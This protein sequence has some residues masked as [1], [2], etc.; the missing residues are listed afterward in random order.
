[1]T[2]VTSTSEPEPTTTPP[3]SLIPLPSICLNMIVKNESKVIRRLLESVVEYLDSYCICDTG[4][5][6][7][8]VD[9]IR[10]F[11]EE[12]HVPG[13]IT[14]EPFRDFG[15]NRTHA[16][17]SAAKMPTNVSDYLLLMDA[18]MVL[19]RDT[20]LSVADVK[21]RLTR[22]R[23]F[24]VYQGTQT[25]KYKNVRILKNRMGATYWG[26]THEYVKMPEGENVPY[27][28]FAHDE[29]FI[30]DIGDGGSKGDKFKRDIRLLQQGLEELPNND[31]YL[32]Y[33]ANSYRDNG[34][35]REAIETYRR[36][37]EVGGWV[38]ELWQCYYSMGKCYQ[39]LGDM[40]N[41]IFQWM[42]AYHTY[43]KRIENLY[44]MVRYY[45]EKGHNELAYTFYIMADNIRNT[46]V[47]RDYLF[48]Q[49]DIYDY[50]LDYELSIVGYYCNPE[51]KNLVDISMKVIR[52]ADLEDE[53]YRNVLSNYKFYA[54]KLDTKYGLTMN[55][56]NV[57]MLHAIGRDVIAP[58]LGEYVPS[59]PS[60]CIDSRTGD[61]VV[62]VRFVNYRINEEGGYEGYTG[63]TQ[64]H[65]G[66]KNV[67]ARFSGVMKN[68]ERA[69][70]KVGDDQELV[71]DP[72]YNDGR[73][74]GLEDVRLF[75]YDKYRGMG[76]GAGRLIYNAN[77]GLEGTQQRPPA[78]HDAAVITVEHGW[79][80]PDANDSRKIT[81]TNSRLLVYEGANPTLEKN[82]VL[83]PY[84]T[85]DRITL[86]CVYK[87]SPLILG[88]VC[89]TAGR[90]TETH[91]WESDTLPRFFRDVRCSTNGVPV[92]R[93]EIWFLGHLV[94]YENR[95]YYYH[96]M[97]VL[98]AKTLALKKYTPLWTFAGGIVEYT[99]GMV[100]FPDTQRFLIGYST[101]DRETKYT[102]VSR[103]VFDE[104]V[105]FVKA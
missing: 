77:R 28:E 49:T 105:G 93:D 35:H 52:H 98:D 14:K 102:M 95:R 67:V 73:Y 83:F 30:R 75:S 10:T 55:A 26:V 40:P 85:D 42:E 43:P 46:H 16:L 9:I 4:S 86:K 51:R 87:W 31:R 5:T 15:Y 32:Y 62:C 8:T 12:H 21:T 50:K 61:L 38:E 6:D 70:I 48:T 2:M 36:R 17:K 64:Y 20:R 39:E 88:T 100:Y 69:W 34:E 56:K 18:D 103:H 99:L 27:G 13:V 3:A 37:I 89:P 29:L 90:F 41:A 19:W 45:R 94:S 66:T 74:T 84:E 60:L 96:V 91:R 44:E 53:L 22:N 33:L 54:P 82:W 101:M 71:C 81:C 11:F 79:M 59:T 1:M 72:T 63:P 68:Y 104:G 58:Y 47:Q 24:L 25:F 76:N 7:D 57:E 23:V 97:L 78:P 92:G 80:V 65:I